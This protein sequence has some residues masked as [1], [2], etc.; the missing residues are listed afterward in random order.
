MMP[1]K[2][3][4]KTRS[5]QPSLANALSRGVAYVEEWYTE[6]CGHQVCDLMHGIRSEQQEVCTAAFKRQC[7]PI[8]HRTSRRPVA[9]GLKLG[10]RRKVERAKQ[11]LRRV[12]PS[13]SEACLLI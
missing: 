11:D 9:S 1:L 8:E 13:E 2:A 12:Q 6:I 5:R 4:A 3:K 10:H 7:L